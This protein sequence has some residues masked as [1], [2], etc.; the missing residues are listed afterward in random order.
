[1]RA[2][3]Y[4]IPAGKSAPTVTQVEL[5]IP[6]TPDG[7][8]LVRV[9]YAGLSN[10]ERETS[11]GKRNRSLA[12]L[13]KRMPVVSG[14]EM[15]GVVA[16]GTDKFKSGDSVVGY[17]NIFRGPFCHADYVA[18]PECKLACIPENISLQGAASIV[19]GV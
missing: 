12:R 2:L 15:A 14:I 4:Q 8:V 6:E 13:K 17:T 19:C 5:P 18:V 3:S 11:E 16:R 1:M 7:A 9:S 10:F